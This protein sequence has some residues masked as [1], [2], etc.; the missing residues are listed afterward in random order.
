MSA[1]HARRRVGTR[2]TRSA[3]S[4]SKDSTNGTDSRSPSGSRPPS[5]RLSQADDIPVPLSSDFEDEQGQILSPSS[6]ISTSS[7]SLSSD[8][9]EAC[10]GIKPQSFPSPLQL[11]QAGNDFEASN[12]ICNPSYA[13][14]HTPS[15]SAFSA[16]VSSKRK[17][18]NNDLDPSSLRRSVRQRAEASPFRLDSTEAQRDSTLFVSQP[19]DLSKLGSSPTNRKD[20]LFMSLPASFHE[21]NEAQYAPFFDLS[22]L[23]ANSS[24]S[25][26]LPAGEI[27]ST[28]QATTTTPAQ[29]APFTAGTLDQSPA[30]D[31][32]QY[33][34]FIAP[35]PST[36]PPAFL[37]FPK[38]P[39]FSGTFTIAPQ[40]IL[41][42]PSSS[43]SSSFCHNNIQS[44]HQQN[45]QT[46]GI[47]NNPQIS[48]TPLNQPT[49]PLPRRAR[50][51]SVGSDTGSII[52]KDVEDD[53]EEEEEEEGDNTAHP[54]D[55]TEAEN[56]QQAEPL[57]DER[58]ALFASQVRRKA[59][60]LSLRSSQGPIGNQN[61]TP[62]TTPIRSHHPTH[63]VDVA[64]P[65]ADVFGWSNDVASGNDMHGDQT[66]G[67][68]IGAGAISATKV[69]PNQVQVS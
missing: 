12:S 69:N 50:K 17:A 26:F 32:L 68:D 5:S 40:A 31:F 54:N 11:K 53:D 19:L 62:T 34:D 9:A 16:S 43:T 22:M 61:H 59:E 27:Q 21:N 3:N 7:S 65:S 15:R 24:A 10:T 64:P 37:S 29:E 66:Q 49:R 41:A 4:K 58:F 44:A 39:K 23:S 60:A 13:S 46:Y 8:N 18:S 42:T 56:V 30:F 36:P 45:Q 20:S 28:H 1:N 48:Q 14:I 33:S 63:G 51:S 55:E 52:I 2:L 57:E 47:G 6:S 67:T 35:F 25:C 38:T